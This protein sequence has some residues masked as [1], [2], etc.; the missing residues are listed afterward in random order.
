MPVGVGGGEVWEASLA[1]MFNRVNSSR[2]L[3]K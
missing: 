1:S 2:E 3:E